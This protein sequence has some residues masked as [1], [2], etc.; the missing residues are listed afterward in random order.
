MTRVNPQGIALH[1]LDC[2]PSLYW[3]IISTGCSWNTGLTRAVNH[4]V[5]DKYCLPNRLGLL[6]SDRP[7]QL[8]IATVQLFEFSICST[9]VTVMAVMFGQTC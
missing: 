3:V 6:C 4:R 9:D 8:A 5:S 2:N 7:A 1:T